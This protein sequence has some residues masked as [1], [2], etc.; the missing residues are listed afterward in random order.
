[1]NTLEDWFNTFLKPAS[2]VFGLDELE[3]W[4]QISEHGLGQVPFEETGIGKQIA[5]LQKLREDFN[6]YRAEEAAYKTAQE[7]SQ[8]IEF[9]KT[10]AISVITSL[11]TAS[12]AN[13][14]VYYWP[15]II[16]FF[17]GFFH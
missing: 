6:K 2:E 9:R 13:L 12:L 4:K 5:E 11:V 10:V 15:S 3:R 14:F 16:G 7:N 8:K 1:M 17:N